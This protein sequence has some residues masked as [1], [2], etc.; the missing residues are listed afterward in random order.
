MRLGK[1]FLTSFLVAT[2]SIQ[3][4]AWAVVSPIPMRPTKVWNASRVQKQGDTE[5]QT[6]HRLIINPDMVFEIGN[7]ISITTPK[8]QNFSLSEVESTLRRAFQGSEI[9]VRSLPYAKAIDIDWKAGNRVVRF[10][11]SE[12]D[13]KV[14]Y[15]SSS[16]RRVYAA[17][18]LHE[19][20]ALMR[21][22]AGISAPGQ[23]RIPWIDRM[24]SW[25]WER[26]WFQSAYA[27]AT[28]S[29]VNI[30][31]TGIPNINKPI[32]V[33][34]VNIPSVPG[35]RNINLNNAISF[36][37]QFNTSVNVDG[38][39]LGQ[40]FVTGSG[41]IADSINAASYRATQALNND[42]KAIQNGADAVNNV[43]RTL[44]KLTSEGKVAKLAAAAAAG[45]ALGTLAISLAVGGVTMAADFLIEA[46][47]HKKEKA[48]L[49]NRFVVAREAYEKSKDQI[50]QLETLLDSFD[51]F[52]RMLKDN[53]KMTREE[54]LTLAPQ[55]LMDHQIALNVNM[56][57]AEDAYRS[58]DV[59]CRNFFV[60]QSAQFKDLVESYQAIIS[61]YGTDKKNSM[62]GDMRENLRKLTEAEGLLQRAR[63]SILTA[64]D[65]WN[66]EMAKAE[67]QAE[68]GVSRA[69]RVDEDVNK[70]QLKREEA[71]HTKALADI[72]KKV[73]AL[74][75]TCV[76]NLS[77]WD[78]RWWFPGKARKKAC[79]QAATG[80][81][82]TF[83][84]QVV[85]VFGKPKDGDVA[86]FASQIREMRI[87]DEYAKIDEE[88]MNETRSYES[89]RV[90]MR[91][92]AEAITNAKQV[93]AVNQDLA[94]GLTE[95]DNE[96]FLKILREQNSSDD[97]V[98]ELQKK[99]AMLKQWCGP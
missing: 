62:C 12:K 38:K 65:V 30:N 74:V 28:C 58:G 96:W 44:Q 3:Q 90:R 57:W 16:F 70:D 8:T 95:A 31:C 91:E 11:V 72:G 14:H 79:T 45:Y 34:N 6:F 53:E 86:K 1:C 69:K 89:S 26:E 29:L 25:L 33:P 78:D 9:S 37:N 54:F 48:E 61:R 5:L 81:E 77:K 85:E 39:Q 4:V 75:N 40:D 43:D 42:A 59:Q 94:R 46:I 22:L 82:L 56:K 63:I 10:F 20:E 23:K 36:S 18:L 15:V 60:A 80:A 87:A 17:P 71:R 52:N 68:T 7:V 21:Q 97:R 13:G 67:K 35:V 84:E 76:E 98:K 64:R 47:T 93:L 66:E 83:D 41:K 24:V 92:T 50:K 51:D 49:L 2:L 32:T 73:D 19:T 99:E 55:R 88:R 27:A